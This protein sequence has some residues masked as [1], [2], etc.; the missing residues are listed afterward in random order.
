M[1]HQAPSQVHSDSIMENA[2]EASDSEHVSLGNQSPVKT[3]F[4]YSVNQISL[5]QTLGGNTL[6]ATY[7]ADEVLQKVIELVK[8]KKTSKI[9]KLPSPWREKFRALSVDRYDFMYM[10]ERLVIPAILRPVILRSQHYGHP[11]RDAMLSTVSA[12]WWPKLHREVA[13]IASSCEQ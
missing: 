4:C 3:P 5:L 6:A 13:T 9:N 11:G 12:V 7:E 8:D 2:S 10:D 1:Q